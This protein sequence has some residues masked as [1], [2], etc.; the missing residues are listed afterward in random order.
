MKNN[1]VNFKQHSCPEIVSL[2]YVKQ[3]NGSWSANSPEEDDYVYY[4]IGDF[5]TG[6]EVRVRSLEILRDMVDQLQLKIY[7]LEYQL[8]CNKHE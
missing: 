8:E 6:K 7:D 1:I 5:K 4:W 2:D 3:H